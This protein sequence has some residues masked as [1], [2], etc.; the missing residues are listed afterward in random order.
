MGKRPSSDVTESVAKRT[1]RS[2]VAATESPEK[3]GGDTPRQS[4][5]SGRAVSTRFL[6][7]IASLKPKTPAK[8]KEEKGIFKIP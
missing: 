7:G 4:L 8:P 1:R 6:E 5:R 3:A 2:N